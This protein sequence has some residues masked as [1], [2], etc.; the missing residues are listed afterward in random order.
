MINPAITTTTGMTTAA[1]ILPPFPLPPP[2]MMGGVMITGS[3]YQGSEQSEYAIPTSNSFEE[4]TM[5]EHFEQV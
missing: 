4:W 5:L 1:A 3:V 2:V